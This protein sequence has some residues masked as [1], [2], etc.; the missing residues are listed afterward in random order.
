VKH[1][2]YDDRNEDE[3]KRD[4]NFEQQRSA[5]VTG[6]SDK[7]PLLR[8]CLLGAK[9]FGCYEFLLRYKQRAQCSSNY[10]IASD[11]D[12]AVDGDEHEEDCCLR[13]ALKG[14]GCDS[15]G[16]GDFGLLFV[17]WDG[18]SVVESKSF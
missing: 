11:A 4:D 7:L 14:G 6:I 16:A 15:T 17:A 18:S 8:E 12:D 10:A 13:Q 1:G 2:A 9:V 3:K 5:L